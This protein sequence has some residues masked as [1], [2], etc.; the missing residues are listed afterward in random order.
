MVIVG[1]EELNTAAL[2]GGLKIVEKTGKAKV[3]TKKPIESV[4][5]NSSV[6]PEVKDST[7]SQQSDE[8]K[9]LF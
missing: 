8:D 2:R 7:E 4:K 6:Q 1:Y 3:K 5:E 9:P